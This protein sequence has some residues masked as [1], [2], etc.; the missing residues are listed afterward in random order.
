MRSSPPAEAYPRDRE[1]DVVLRDGSTVH[2]RPVRA[3]DADAIRTFLEALSPESIGFRFFGTPNLDWVTEW[4]VDVDYADRFA[5][6]AESGSPRSVIAHAAYVTNEGGKSA[7]VAFLVAD[8]WQGRGIST[9]LLAH[10]AEVADRHGITTF[11]AEVL[12]ANHR[13]IEVFR[14]SGF[15]VE[16]RSTPDAIAIELPTSLSA[17]ALERFEERERTRVGRG[18]AQLPGAAV[19]RG[20]RGIAAPGDGRRRGA[21]QPARERVRAA[22]LTPSTTTPTS[23]SPSRPTAPSPTFRSGRAGGDRRSRQRR[24]SGWPASAR[25]P[26][27][28]RCS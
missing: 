9:I 7:E 14:E 27:C 5:L 15:P 28:A 11:T 26:A 1:A 21:P 23:S 19:G 16:M 18:G 4:S 22:P 12:P 2:V 3:D 10:L 17:E 8:A 13:M 6:V 24:W 20:D 25:P